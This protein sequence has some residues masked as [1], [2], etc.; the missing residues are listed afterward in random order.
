M[1]LLQ[2]NDEAHAVLKERGT[3]GSIQQVMNDFL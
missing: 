2:L 3:L 1:Q